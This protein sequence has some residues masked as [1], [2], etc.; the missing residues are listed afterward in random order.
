VSA[1]LRE[2]EDIAAVSSSKLA[3]GFKSVLDAGVNLSRSKVDE[4]P[5]D[6]ED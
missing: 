2:E 5:G 1:I 4:L 3:N 6:V